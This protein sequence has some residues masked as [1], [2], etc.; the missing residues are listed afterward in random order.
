MG[1]LL[2]Y[3]LQHADN[4]QQSLSS[5]VGLTLYLALPALEALHKAWK[6]HSM[7]SKYKAFHLW[8]NAA[9]LKIGEYY[10][11]TAELDAYTIAMCR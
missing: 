4:A 1:R 2:I 3:Y 10:E 7:Q 5:D 6:S 8:L 9:I 11:C